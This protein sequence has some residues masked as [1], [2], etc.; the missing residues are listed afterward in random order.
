MRESERKKAPWIDLWPSFPGED[1]RWLYL[2]KVQKAVMRVL[3]ERP[4]FPHD[5][6]ET[7]E[8][9]RLAKYARRPGPKRELPRSL[10]PALSSVRRAL[11]TLR[12]RGLITDMWLI[13]RNWHGYP[14]SRHFYYPAWWGPTEVWDALEDANTAAQAKA[15]LRQRHN[16]AAEQA[17]KI[18]PTRP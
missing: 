15:D 13:G 1:A 16:L 17:M 3:V 5:L 11:Y 2:G 18:P 7:L 10:G 14:L 8:R 12:E 4:S 6:W 9:E